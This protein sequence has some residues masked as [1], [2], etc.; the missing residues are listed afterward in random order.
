MKRY[1]GWKVR[2]L[3]LCCAGLVTLSGCIQGY[4]LMREPDGGSVSPPK[5]AGSMDAT[6]GR[7]ASSDTKTDGGARDAVFPPSGDTINDRT[8][9][10]SDGELFGLV[11]P[12]LLT[13]GASPGG[14]PATAFRLRSTA[15]SDE[16]SGNFSLSPCTFSTKVSSFPQNARVQAGTTVV[17]DCVFEPRTATLR[18]TDPRNQQSITSVSC[19]LVED[20]EDTDPCPGGSGGD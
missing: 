14:A 6:A 8:F 7:D 10:F 18:L 12:F 9:E 3:Q 5:D 17:L 4:E 11:N 1:E 13:I 2:A 15:N 19:S 20:G 16:A